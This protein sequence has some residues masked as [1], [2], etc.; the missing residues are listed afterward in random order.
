MV[1][2]SV[3]IVVHIFLYPFVC[4]HKKKMQIRDSCV[5]MLLHRAPSGQKLNKAPLRCNVGQIG[6]FVIFCSTCFI[7][8]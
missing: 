7:K 2:M 1:F 4:L 5:K 8:I 3:G 6:I